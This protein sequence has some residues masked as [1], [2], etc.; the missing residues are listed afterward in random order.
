V[1]PTEHG[2]RQREDLCRAVDVA[3]AD[4]R[5][6]PAE[7]LVPQ[8]TSS[9]GQKGLGL[10]A[11]LPAIAPVLDGITISAPYLAGA[12]A[13]GADVPTLVGCTHEEVATFVALDPAMQSVTRAQSIQFVTG[14]VG[15]GQ[16]T[17]SPRWSRAAWT[18]ARW[19][20]WSTSRRRSS[21]RT[22]PS[23]LP[24]CVPNRERRRAC[25]S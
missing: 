9:P 15:T 21:S 4:L 23:T 20:P 2:D 6:A 16:P 5:S 7:R 22:V 24:V 1:W 25:T 8:L 12:G 14:L 18:T 10:G 13:G 17:S 3:E 19:R 11:L